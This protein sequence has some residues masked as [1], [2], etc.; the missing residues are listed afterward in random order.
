MSEYKRVTLIAKEVHQCPLQILPGEQMIFDLPGI[1]RES[2]KICA[3]VAQA[4]LPS[5][6]ALAKGNASPSSEDAP[7]P[8][9]RCPSSNHIVWDVTIDQASSSSATRKSSIV[10]QDLRRIP[11][12]AS[13]PDYKMS[14]II[15][16]LVPYRC[17]PEQVLAKQHE[18]YQALF[19]IANG[20]VDILQK[21]K[22]GQE[23]ILTKLTRHDYFGE[24]SLIG[25]EVSS[26]TIRPATPR[27]FNPLI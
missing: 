5:L 8:S 12:F 26:V 9:F 11:F 25:K 18:E 3:Y 4:F 1:S 24:M 21:S 19:L 23:V 17:G 2:P 13:L 27:D 6:L 20:V 15:E 10:E 22:E 16:N 14:K 7:P